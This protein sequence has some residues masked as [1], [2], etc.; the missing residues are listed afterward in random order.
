MFLYV[1]RHPVYPSENVQKHFSKLQQSRKKDHFSSC[2]NR[3][4]FNLVLTSLVHVLQA[5]RQQEALLKKRDVR[6]RKYVGE[7]S[8]KINEWYIRDVIVENVA[9]L[10]L[11]FLSLK[12]LQCDSSDNG[13]RLS[14]AMA[15]L[16]YT[17]TDDVNS[18]RPCL[19]R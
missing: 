12:R 19:T 8:R 1:L 18:A 11:F 6:N 10:K 17:T 16:L 15:A 7:A 9:L 4:P 14:T 2:E 13:S 5:S 3:F